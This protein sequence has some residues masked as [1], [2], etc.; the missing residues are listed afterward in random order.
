MTEEEILNQWQTEGRIDPLQLGNESLR[1]TQLHARYYRLYIQAEREYRKAKDDLAQV[2]KEVYALYKDGPSKE[3][4]KSGRVIHASLLPK[5][6]INKVQELQVYIDA[7]PKY[8]AAVEQVAQKNA[9]V[10]LLKSILG[11][12]NNWN[13]T[14]GDAIKDYQFKLGK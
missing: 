13:F 3:D 12:I 14:V 9:I 7:D 8:I 5:G 6:A 4:L 10:G 11:I 1:K 2:H